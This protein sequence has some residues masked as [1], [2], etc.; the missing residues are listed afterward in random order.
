M[1]HWNKVHVEKKEEG[2]KSSCVCVCVCVLEKWG[3]KRSSSHMQK[4]KKQP[5]VVVAQGT[6]LMILRKMSLTLWSRFWVFYLPVTCVGIT[7][8]LHFDLVWVRKMHAA[9]SSWQCFPHVMLLFAILS[10]SCLLENEKYRLAW[11]T[12][13]HS[14]PCFSA[15]TSKLLH[16]WRN[17]AWLCMSPSE[18]PKRCG[19]K[20]IWLELEAT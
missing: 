15:P 20:L 19:Y 12:Y 14:K 10:I 13:L 17:T 11:P 2:R 6:V 7:F 9:S 5:L 1:W 18:P 8:A 3:P 16:H 4:K